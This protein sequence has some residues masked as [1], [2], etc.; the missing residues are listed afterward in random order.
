[1]RLRASITGAGRGAIQL[2]LGGIR[3]QSLELGPLE[4][5]VDVVGVL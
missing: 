5:K 3:I 1:M 4:A 2:Q